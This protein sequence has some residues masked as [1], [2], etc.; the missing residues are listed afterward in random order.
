MVE[1]WLLE[2][3][4][5]MI[6]DIFASPARR[7]LAGRREQGSMALGAL[8]HPL[9]RSSARRGASLAVKRGNEQ[10]DALGGRMATGMTTS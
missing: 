6:N 8:R 4:Q 9:A 1:Y 5:K 3:D 10:Q 7:S 2:R